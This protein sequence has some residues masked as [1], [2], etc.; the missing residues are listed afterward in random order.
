[1][2]LASRRLRQRERKLRKKVVRGKTGRTR[3][4]GSC[5][6]GLC[7]DV[8]VAVWKGDHGMRKGEWPAESLSG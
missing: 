1:M 4:N 7:W 6:I 5:E 2:R 3:R 8:G